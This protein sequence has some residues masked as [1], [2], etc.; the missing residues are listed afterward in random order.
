M[1]DFELLK[2]YKMYLNTVQS[3]F[4]KYFDDQKEYISCKAGCSHC[5]EKGAYPC[6]RLEFDYMMLGFFKLDMKVQQGVIKRI[7]ELKEKYSNEEN[8]NKL[9]Y[10]CPF[11]DENGSCTIYE[12]R[13][14][15]CRTFGLLIV[16][17]EDKLNLP[18]CHSLGLNYSKVYNPEKHEIDAELV[19][20]HGYKVTP[21]GY[22]IHLKILL[23]KEFLQDND[24]DF[25]EVKSLI[26]WL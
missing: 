5:C 15:I 20:K 10:R 19:K 6:T 8:L 26:E 23:K 2:K 4:D 18:F 9:L 13:P 22:P 25:G 3:F 7:Q 12:F 11:L 17:T 24:F 14:L 16:D 21:K 1:L